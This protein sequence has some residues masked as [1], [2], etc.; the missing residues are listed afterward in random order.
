MNKYLL[1]IC[2]RPH[3]R[4]PFVW[5]IGFKYLSQVLYEKALRGGD[6]LFYDCARLASYFSQITFFNRDVKQIQENVINFF[7]ERIIHMLSPQ[8]L[9]EAGALGSLNRLDMG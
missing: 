8:D 1:I 3:T 4:S 5:K 7:K 9:C 2:Q 6:D